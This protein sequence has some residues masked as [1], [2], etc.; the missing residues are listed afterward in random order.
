MDIISIDADAFFVLSGRMHK[1]F[2]YIPQEVGNGQVETS[3]YRIQKLL[4]AH[5]VSRTASVR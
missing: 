3:R 4:S 2:R 1:G 5:A